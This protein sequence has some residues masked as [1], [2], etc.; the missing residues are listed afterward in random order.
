MDADFINEL[1]V[2]AFLIVGTAG[3]VLLAG[4]VLKRFGSPKK[5]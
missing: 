1:K 2:V 5:K 4:W 3:I